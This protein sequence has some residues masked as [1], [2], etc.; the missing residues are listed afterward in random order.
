MTRPR[1]LLVDLLDDLRGCVM[2]TGRALFD[3]CGSDPARCLAE[4]CTAGCERYE[5]NGGEEG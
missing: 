3:G 2:P 1:S 5:E 4:G